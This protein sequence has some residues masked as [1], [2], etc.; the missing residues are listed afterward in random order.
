MQTINGLC[1]NYI[2]SEYYCTILGF[3][4]PCC[5]QYTYTATAA[6]NMGVP[7]TGKNSNK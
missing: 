3:Q 2:Y 4:M 6:V 1:V 7:D 5:S